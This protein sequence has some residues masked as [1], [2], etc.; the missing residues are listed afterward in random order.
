VHLL[1]NHSL[2]KDVAFLHP[3]DAYATNEQ[4]LLSTV[5]GSCVSVVLW[6]KRLKQGGMNHFMLPGNPKQVFYLDEH[7][8]YGMYAMELLVNQLIKLGSI[9][10]NLVAKVFGGAM[11]LVSTRSEESSI[12]RANINFAYNY[13][14]VEGFPLV[15]SDVGG[16]QARKILLDPVTGKVMLKRLPHIR[17]KQV[18]SEEIE[19]LEKLKSRSTQGTFIPFSAEQSEE[20]KQ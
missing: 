3:G 11:V 19:Y 5:L 4:I 14:E 1:H 20:Q 6:D 7:G 2:G 9:R 10:S 17:D 15:S 16:N 12:S 8:K 18:Q 13:L